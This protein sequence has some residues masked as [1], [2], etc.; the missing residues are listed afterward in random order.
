MDISYEHLKT[1]YQV[2]RYRSFT[3][4]AVELGTS[5]PAVTR[6]I[7]T[8]ENQIGCKLFFRDKHSVLLTPEG[9]QLYNYV[10]L[11]CEQFEKGI[12]TVT[13]LSNL[14]NGRLMICSNEISLRGF[15]DDVM[16]IYHQN[17][18]G[19]M[20]SLKNTPSSVALRELNQGVTDF[21]FIT[22]DHTI[23]KPYHQIICRSFRDVPLLG[24][25]YQKQRKIRTLD[26]LS[27]ISYICMGPEHGTYHLYEQFF[28]EHGKTMHV[29][30]YTDS[31]ALITP[32]LEHDLGY[33]FMPEFIAEEAI[34]AGRVFSPEL[35]EKMR[36]R[37][38]RMIYDSTYPL[39]VA[40]RAFLATVHEYI[41]GR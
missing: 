37:N 38:I 28:Q 32:M 24:T 5:Q 17:Y 12:S 30:M 33:A 41:K 27:D 16:G 22:S 31:F 7:G 25:L 11:G 15:L 19:V 21:A 3:Q 40:A 35:K 26:D 13:E 29:D 9:Q 1:F 2:A 34:A 6:L 39:S 20:I 4:A 10:S 36:R 8:L 23:K 18:P 14:E